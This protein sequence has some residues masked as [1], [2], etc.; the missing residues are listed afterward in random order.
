MKYDAIG[1]SDSCGGGGLG[2]ASK[3]IA[4][5]RFNKIGA[6]MPRESLCTVIRFLIALAVCSQAAAAAAAALLLR[7]Q[8]AYLFPIMIPKLS[9]CA[10]RPHQY[11]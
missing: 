5:R 11:F 1:G 10:P 3:A 7:R 9:S 4:S 8:M 6:F 2:V